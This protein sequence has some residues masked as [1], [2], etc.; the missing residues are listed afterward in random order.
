MD[1]LHQQQKLLASF[2]RLDARYEKLR[3]PLLQELAQTFVVNPNHLLEDGAASEDSKRSVQ[4]PPAEA[5]VIKALDWIKKS[6]DVPKR[7]RW[8]SW[9]H[10]K[11]ETLV[12]KLSEFNNK[13]HEALDRAQMNSLLEMQT[14]TNYQIVL[15]NRQ[16]E[17]MVQIWQSDRVAYRHPHGIV[18]DID[19]PEYDSSNSI[20][21]PNS[22]SLTQPLGALAQQRFVHLAIEDSHNFS[23]RFADSIDLRGL[24]GQIQDTVL[25]LGDIKPI[26]ETFPEEIE[27]GDRTEATYKGASVWVEVSRPL[28]CT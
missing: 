18:M 3:K 17:N 24:A 15:L 26:R 1:I 20:P 16:M 8:A 21:V 5:L 14:R 2:G 28:L 19:D 22:R 12:D 6:R 23:E 25:A 10:G 7:L 9:D 13:M 4:F 11:M 27:E